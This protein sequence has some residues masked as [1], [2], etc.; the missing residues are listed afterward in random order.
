MNR[1]RLLVSSVILFAILSAI[2]YPIAGHRF[3]EAG[4]EHVATTPNIALVSFFDFFSRNAQAQNDQT[5]ENDR[6]DDQSIFRSIPLG[7]DLDTFF[8]IYNW[9]RELPSTIPAF[10]SYA[11]EQEATVGLVGSILLV[12]FIGTV[13]YSILWQKRVVGFI[14]TELQPLLLRV[15]SETHPRLFAFVRILV[16]PVLPLF[17]LAVALLIKGFIRY[18]VTWMVL[19]IWLLELW[20]MG[21]L[22]IKIL[23]ET[24]RGDLMPFCPIY[25][26]KIFRTLRLTA[27]Y[28]I[29]GIAVVWS[30]ELFQLPDDVQAFIQFVVSVTVVCIAAL[31]F[32]DREMVLSLLPRLPSRGYMVFASFVIRAYTPIAIFTVLLG[33]LWCLGYRRLSEAVLVKTWGAALA[34]VAIMLIYRALFRRLVA[35][36]NIKENLSSETALNYFQ[37]AKV[38]IQ[39]ST[40]I[41]GTFVVLDLLGLFRPL[42]DFLS[43]PV[44]TIGDT[45]LSFWVFF[46]AMFI[47]I[48]FSYVSRLLQSYLDF[49]IYPS[50]GVDPGLGY[51][52]NMF[53][54]YTLFAV[55]ALIALRII[56]L[57]LRVLM[58]FAGGVGIGAGIG[59]Q[60]IASNILSGFL[61]VFGR[62]LRK[63]DWIKVGDKLGMVTQIHLQSTRIWTRDNIEL[64]IPNTELVSKQITNYT[65]S[66]PNVRLHIPVGVDWKSDP[67]KVT[68]ILLECAE[69]TKAATHVRKP[70]VRVSG[71][72]HDSLD[73]DIL[74]WI[75]A[76]RISESDIKS[77]IYYSVLEGLKAAGIE[78]RPNP[79]VDIF[80]RRGQVPGGA[81]AEGGADAEEMV[82]H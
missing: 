20:A 7:W 59:L 8:S 33:L 72:S 6:T 45:P 47:L 75:D 79:E 57:D 61:I 30:A 65:M 40:A 41:I 15:P 48:A 18:E 76:R 67:A 22:I 73:F 46:A 71:F 38:F 53:L 16:A 12:L 60:H 44:Y 49:R 10:F 11:M 56:G 68:K 21:A 23:R 1:E 25:G 52:L 36:S 80:V 37:T 39:Y 58:V 9:A 3:Q 62:R 78:I 19:V 14:E 51:A 55:S 26:R 24:L 27:V 50:V 74:I 13:I 54:K 28:A 43:R 29:A 32:R 70:Q 17:L 2:I 35:M 42:H 64:L 82:P 31:I 5:Q 63:G 77:K 81:Q 4:R 34:Y 66:S 69:K